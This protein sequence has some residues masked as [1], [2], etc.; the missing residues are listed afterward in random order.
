M[1]A[2][3]APSPGS[4]LRQARLLS[5]S[6]VQAALLAQLQTGPEIIKASQLCLQ[7]VAAPEG[8]DDVGEFPEI[9]AAISAASLE[10]EGGCLQKALKYTIE[11]LGI[12]RAGEEKDTAEQSNE[13]PGRKVSAVY[14]MEVAANI[15]LQ[16]A[17]HV[18]SRKAAEDAVAEAEALDDGLFDVKIGALGTLAASELNS[19]RFAAAM[20][21]F[22]K[23][24][25][26]Q[27]RFACRR[28]EART[29]LLMAI[30]LLASGSLESCVDIARSALNIFMEFNDRASILAMSELI[31]AILLRQR[32]TEEAKAL[33][34][35][36]LA[37]AQELGNVNLEAN[38]LLRSGQCSLSSKEGLRSCLD[39]AKLFGEID[40][41]KAQGA[42]L[43]SAANAMIVQ[44]PPL[45]QEAV[46]TAKQGLSCCRQA[47]DKQGEA[48]LTHTL[49]NC[50]FA[51]RMRDEAISA[52]YQTLG[53][54]ED[55]QDSYGQELACKLLLSAGQSEGQLKSRKNERRN[56]GGHNFAPWTPEQVLWETAWVPIEMQDPKIFGEKASTGARRVFVV[57]ELQ[58]SSLRRQITEC[59]RKWVADK[60]ESEKEDAE[61]ETFLCNK[62]DGRLLTA[63]ELKV[64]FAASRCA[65]V[66]YDATQLNHMGPLEVIDV[67]LRVIQ[68]MLGLE[69]QQVALDVVTSSCQALAR[70]KGLREPFHAG[71]WGLNR[72][73]RL[74][75][76]T[77][78]LRTLDIDPYS[79]K[80]DMAFIARWLLG[81][82]QTRPPEVIFRNGVFHVARLVAARLPLK[83]PTNELRYPSVIA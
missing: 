8:A 19:G 27:T 62:L 44:R 64:G 34:P 3:A 49:A 30:T 63:S 11:A 35:L 29:Q 7:N 82:Q 25:P 22:G 58:D 54:F 41:F 51:L 13:A 80:D 43:H 48:I 28:G 17:N 10:L 39:A 72:G 76:P 78:E 4:L 45:V 14:L 70:T 55:C 75:N 71:L 12:L 67:V 31:G 15:H 66:V 16:Q 68:A 73:A 38:S 47:Q 53:L 40:D 36:S 59:C 83:E 24:L 79:A 21:T 57:S 18:R 46:E 1:V 42:A 23:R 61:T 26:L 56:G 65:A 81:A 6:K 37:L 2:L 77:T 33:A 20:R 52:A 50:Y 74:E 32:N 9:H 5:A 60:F 69:E